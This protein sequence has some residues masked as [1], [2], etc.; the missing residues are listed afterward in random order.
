MLYEFTNKEKD[1]VHWSFRVGNFNS[2]R[3]LPRHLLPGN[4]SE[5]NRSK[6]ESNLYSQVEERSYIELSNGGGFFQKF[7]YQDDPFELY[8]EQQSKDRQA[9]D[10][11]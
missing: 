7:K 9:S 3:D 1:R 5:W 8:L 11:I 10:A 2:L 6:I 4:V